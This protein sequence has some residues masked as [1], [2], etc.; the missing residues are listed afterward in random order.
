MR[1][2]IF[3]VI[4]T[5]GNSG[6]E[7]NLTYQGAYRGMPCIEKVAQKGNM[8]AEKLTTPDSA[9]SGLRKIIDSDRLQQGG[10][11]SMTLSRC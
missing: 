11:S 3:Y 1:R 10:R 6:Q 5:T 4:E 2:C 8:E 9:T 7:W